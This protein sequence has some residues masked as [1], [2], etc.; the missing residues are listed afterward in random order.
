MKETVT[1]SEPV[2]HKNTQFEV[3]WRFYF[4]LHMTVQILT[5]RLQRVNISSYNLAAET[6]NSH[7]VYHCSNYPTLTS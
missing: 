2:Q 7:G 4:A 5:T 1:F 6:V 3:N